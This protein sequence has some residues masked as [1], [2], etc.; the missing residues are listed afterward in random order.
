MA[1]NLLC[2]LSAFRYSA[3]VHIKRQ[4]QL[5]QPITQIH[6]H[7]WID[8]VLHGL[9]AEALST[10]LETSASEF[11]AISNVPHSKSAVERAILSSLEVQ[12]EEEG[13]DDDSWL[14][15]AR[16]NARHTPSLDAIDLDRIAASSGFEVQ[17]SWTRQGP[18]Y[19]LDAIFFRNEPSSDSGTSERSRR[20]FNFPCV[21]HERGSLDLCNVPLRLRSQQDIGDRLHGTL[22]QNLSSYMVPRNIF[23]LDVLPLTSNGKLDRRSLA[24]QALA[25][26]RISDARRTSQSDAQP[27]SEAVMETE[28]QIRMIWSR[29][30]QIDHRKIQSNT[31]F[32]ELGGTSMDIIKVIQAARKEGLN[33]RAATMFQYP[34]LSDLAMHVKL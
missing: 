16:E 29:V 15:T 5:L 25:H 32:F 30:L 9:D 11:V 10:L 1:D 18:S 21:H 7:Q 13:A 23:V 28:A 4:V 20:L 26:H 24:T 14:S 2:R 17:V 22:S 8:F 19:G 27:E 6:E 33:L 3:I 34:K 12:K 31:S